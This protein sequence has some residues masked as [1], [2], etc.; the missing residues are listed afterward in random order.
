MPRKRV[1]VDTNVILE[2][3]R[4]NAWGELTQRCQVETVEMCR[5]E[6]LTGDASKAGYIP[7]DSGVLQGGCH[8]IHAVTQREVDCLVMEHEKMLNLDAGEL[9]LFA[10]LHANNIRLS[11]V[12]VLSTADKGAIVRANDNPMWLDW[13][14]SLQEV[15]TQARVPR[16]KVDALRLQ[17]TSA[18]LSKVRLDVRNGVIP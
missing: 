7:V 16:Q 4:I 10:Y 1:F 2:C 3:F 6:A 14:Q 11:D 9:H 15:L 5:S 8:K 13:L 12:A 17:H 18:F